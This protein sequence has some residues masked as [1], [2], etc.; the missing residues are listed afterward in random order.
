MKWKSAVVFGI[1]AAGWMSLGQPD[2]PDARISEA[3]PPPDVPRRSR[4]RPP[5]RPA[6]VIR[7]YLSSKL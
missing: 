1:L 5:P 7:K 6:P 2:S 4:S 3:A